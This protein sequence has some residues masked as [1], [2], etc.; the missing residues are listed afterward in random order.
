MT[1]VQKSKLVH[2]RIKKNSFVYIP[3]PYIAHYCAYN[4]T[5]L[6]VLPLNGL[7]W[8][9]KLGYVNVNTL[10]SSNNLIYN[11]LYSNHY[12]IEKS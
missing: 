2:R 4:N 6:L 7:G 9:V 11:L 12:H 8:W 1:I 3:S 5:N 10:Q